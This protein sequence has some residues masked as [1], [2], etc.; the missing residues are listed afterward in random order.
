MPRFCAN[1]TMMFTEVPFLDRFERA[2][3]A[4]FQAVEMLFPYEAPASEVR[5]A[6]NGAGVEIALFNAPPGSWDN[7]DRGLAAMPGKQAEFQAAFAQAM[8]YAAVLQSRSL[9]LM[10]GLTKDAAAT[11]TL[12]ENLRWAAEQAPDQQMAIEPINTRDIPGYFLNT[13]DQAIEILDAAG[14]PNIGLQ[15]DIY[16][17]QIMEG[18]LTRRL[19]RLAK[20]IVH[21]QLAG[22]PDRHEPDASEVGLSHVMAV[23]DRIGFAGWVGCEYRPAGRTEDGLSW[24][25]QFDVP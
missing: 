19:E 9:H 24:L 18:D 16:H 21:V 7:G 23:L 12:I 17:V 13:T 20:R 4:G 8:D 5:A 3:R 14:A 6:A 22:V 11:D 1:L 2:A 25:R 15:F 10:S